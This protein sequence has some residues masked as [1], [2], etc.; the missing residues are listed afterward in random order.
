L[1]SG[2]IDAFLPAKLLDRVLPRNKVLAT[3]LSGFLGLVFP[4][5]ECA[6][7]PVVRRLVRKGLPISCAITYLLSAPIIN[8]IV[9][10]STLNAFKNVD[11]SEGVLG[12]VGMTVARISLG[13]V[14]AVIVGISL[15][16]KRPA[17][18]LHRDI[19]AAMEKA[20]PSAEGTAS[21]PGLSFNA[22]LVSAMR[23][24]KDDFLDTAM[25]FAIGV[26]ITSVFNTQVDQAAVE[27]MVAGNDLLAIPS[28]MGLAFVL[29]LCSTSDAFIAAPMAAFS[30]SAK[31]AFL[32][33]GPM[34]DVKLVFMYSS[35]FRR[36][37]MIGLCLAM[38]VLVAAL[39]VPWVKMIGSLL[40]L[41]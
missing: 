20:P 18:V 23:T 22:K 7:V 11:A 15:L 37:F 28:L 19:A 4:V 31:L 12:S 27:R 29:A 14:I 16:R 30:S 2:F 10:F 39:V 38:F 35:L 21:V 26:A 6:V 25:Y 40:P 17:D 41:S 36:K 1:I 24:A 33:F 9:I 8:P 34:L 13:Y 3:V 5:C 32:V